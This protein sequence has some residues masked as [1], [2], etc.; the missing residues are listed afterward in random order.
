MNHPIDLTPAQP[1]PAAESPRR[2]AAADACQAQR[3]RVVRLAGSPSRHAGAI[4]DRPRW[5][6]R[7]LC[8]VGLL[9]VLLAMAA[10]GPG[11]GGTGTGESP[12]PGLVAFGA[13]PQSV[14]GA[15]FASALNCPAGT[16][17]N[18]TPAA[19]GTASVRFIDA[20]Q[21]ANLVVEISGNALRLDALCQGLHFNGDWGTTASSGT[22]FYGSYLL[23]GSLQRVNATF[24]VQ[25]VAG[26]TAG[27]LTATL[28]DAD[29]RLVL[30]PL[31]LRPAPLPLPSPGKC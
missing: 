13:T 10:C 3:S 21:G 20:G 7:L 24:A 9:P 23:D 1:V 22:R 14:C 19:D 11:V 2:R 18:P 16:A 4:E 5:L 15:G 6:R 30:G 29:G 27:E 31:T 17:A 12:P 8:T 28:R 25:A 26:S